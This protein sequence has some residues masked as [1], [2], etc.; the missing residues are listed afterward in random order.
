MKAVFKMKSVAKIMCVTK[1]N[2]LM[3]MNLAQLT[4]VRGRAARCVTVAQVQRPEG[5]GSAPSVQPACMGTELAVRPQR[6]NAFSLLE[7]LMAL[8]VCSLLMVGVMTW[9]TNM[10]LIWQQRDENR[11]FKQHCEGVGTFLTSVFARSET[12]EEGSGTEAN[13]PVAWARPP[14]FDERDDPLLSFR[15]EEPP[16]LLVAGTRPLPGVTGYLY[17]KGNLIQILWHSRL[18]ELEEDD[19]VYLTTL[20]TYLDS[21]EYAYRNVEDESWETAVDPE[22]SEEDSSAFI[23]PDFIKLTFKN[24]EGQEHTETVQIPGHSPTTPIF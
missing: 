1:M 11:F 15:V 23:L 17:F 19:E 3:K 10:A 22:T 20:S 18:Q 6:A 5:F 21:V 13:A 12:P 24:D 7:I 4:A 2:S 14:G 16:A 8:A 9:L